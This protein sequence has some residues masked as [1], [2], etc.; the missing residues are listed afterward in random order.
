MKLYGVIG[1]EGFHIEGLQI[2]T[3]QYIR[4][5]KNITDLDTDVVL[6]KV[7]RL[8]AVN[9]NWN[10]DTDDA[11][12]NI[13]FIAQQLE[14][15]FPEFVMTDVNGFK[16]VAYGS[17]TPVLVESIKKLNLNIIDLDKPD[18]TNTWRDA[19]ISWLGN[20]ANGITQIFAEKITAKQ[21]LCIDDLCITKDQLRNMI[22]STNSSVPINPIIDDITPSEVFN[23]KGIEPEIVP[24]LDI[25]VEIP[26]DTTS[27][28]PP[29][30]D[31]I[32]IEA[33]I[34]AVIEPEIVP[35]LDIPVI[36]E[37]VQ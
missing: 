2:S 26:N 30:S 27:D 20:I 33:V 35:V 7:L 36:T 14:Q 24:V 1:V 29:E 9:Y 23:D 25:P 3:T 28:T 17:L 5:K 22:N 6:D 32:V 11:R 31:D 34:E 15:E 12:K 10:A 16:G 13:G 19:I 21:E 18:K 4:M 37:V 8:Q